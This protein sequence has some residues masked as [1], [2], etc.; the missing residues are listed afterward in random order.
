MLVTTAQDDYKKQRYSSQAGLR[1]RLNTF[2]HSGRAQ[3]H[4]AESKQVHIACACH[5]PLHQPCS[6]GAVNN[7]STQGVSTTSAA[8]LNNLT[9]QLSCNLT[10]QAWR[11]GPCL[12]YMTLQ[13]CPV[14]MNV[15]GID[16][17]KACLK[18][19]TGCVSPAD[20][21]DMRT[22]TLQQSPCYSHSSQDA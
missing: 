5:M 13:K 17:Q 2:G 11:P 9:P 16:V 21:P 18:P 22:F 20:A 4:P 12:L 1:K 7:P 6:S 8:V 15:H 19:P 3:R 14:T 10:S